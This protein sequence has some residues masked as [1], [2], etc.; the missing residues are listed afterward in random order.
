M[1]MLT[2]TK[3]GPELVIDNVNIYGM[4]VIMFLLTHFTKKDLMVENSYRGVLNI[5][6]KF[7]PI[8]F[9]F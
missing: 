6:Y 4:H 8:N 3:N 2:R 7:E 9:P 1:Y 5:V